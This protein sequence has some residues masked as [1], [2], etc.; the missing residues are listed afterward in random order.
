MK[1]EPFVIERVYN[2]SVERVW[3]AMTDKNEMKGWYFNL[4]AFKAVP[5]FEFEFTGTHDDRTY[6]HKCRIQEVI[7]NRKLSY[8]WTYDGIKGY[9][10]VS[11]ELFPEGTKTRLRLTHTGI[12][13]FPADNHDFDRENFV[14]G[15]TQIVNENLAG[16][17]EKQVLSKQV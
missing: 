7:P 8:S 14:E 12:E 4:A 13:T 1:N 11:F 6:L 16:Y 3:K 10:E 17:L 2:A 5:G 15:W 9:S